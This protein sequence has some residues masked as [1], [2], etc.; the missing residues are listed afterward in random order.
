MQDFLG[1]ASAG[2][3]IKIW[4]Y[5]SM[6][7]VEYFNPHISPSGIASLSWST[8]NDFLA[9]AACSG[10]KIVISA[11]HS[12]AVP[13]FE[14]AEGENQTILHFDKKSQYLV[15]GGVQN[16]V[17]IWE[18]T[19]RTLYRSHQK[20][21][22]AVTCV[23]FNGSGRCIASG[24]TSGEIIIHEVAT[25]LF[26]TPFGNGWKQPIRRLN[27]SLRKKELLACISDIA[28]VN[29]WDVCKQKCY[30][31]FNAEHTSP[32]T[33]ICA[34]PLNDWLL[35][36]VGLDQKL[37]LYDAAEKNSIKVVTTESPLTTADFMPDG[38]TLMVG[39][40]CGRIY[41]FD[42]RT[43]PSTVPVKTVQAHKSSIQSIQFQN[44]S[45]F[46]KS[47][48]RRSSRRSSLFSGNKRES[49]KKS[50]TSGGSRTS[51]MGTTC[52]TSLEG[53]SSNEKDFEKYVESQ[54]KDIHRRNSLCDMFSPVTNGASC[55]ASLDEKSSNTKDYIKCMDSKF[56]DLQRRSGLCDMFFPFENETTCGAS[57]CGKHP[58]SKVFT[59]YV[60]SQIKEVHRRS[61]LCDMFSPVRN[62]LEAF[63]ANYDNTAKGEGP[64]LATSMTKEV[65]NSVSE[66]YADTI[67]TDNGSPP[68]TATQI[69]MIKDMIQDAAEDVRESCHREIINLQ[70]EM[71]KQFHMQL[72]EIHALIGAYF[73]N[74]EL[75]RETEKLREEN[76]RLRKLCFKHV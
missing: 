64:P 70:V 9:S 27:F 57:T 49:L 55:G 30:H 72:N 24:S 46:A 19:T 28:T 22:G 44:H 73:V 40:S 62:D 74:D 56:K 51:N 52:R 38:H 34:C 76:K 29:L 36:S 13:L 37:I 45:F 33:E 5:A 23:K 39:S 26:S 1:F 7:V 48:G 6:E 41:Q 16:I 66:K 65:D 58:N 21:K 47:C 68:L 12:S 71:I 35:V 4:D 18:L 59:K 53:K 75:M 69:N 60:D 67:E 10:D 63:R 17:N 3:D 32:A 54:F 8:D 25:N 2:E 61:S 11:W 31:M 50:I 20:H 15:S 14:L 42:L 43:L